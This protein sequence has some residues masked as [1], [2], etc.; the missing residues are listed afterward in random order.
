VN[1][2]F[3]KIKVL[4]MLLAEETKKITVHIQPKK[5][6]VHIQPKKITV[7]ILYKQQK[8]MLLVS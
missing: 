2:S 3:Q 5:I 1:K 7:H 4:V 6:T 8:H